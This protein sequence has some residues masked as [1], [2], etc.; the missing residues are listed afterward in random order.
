MIH[1]SALY[2]VENPP[3]NEE[4]KI[5]ANKD[6][7]NTLFGPYI[8]QN[9]TGKK[10]DT[11]LIP[12]ETALDDSQYDYVAIFFGADYCPHCKL[13]APKL[14]E[15]YDVLKAKKCKVV[16]ASNDRTAEA[17]DATC[18]KIAGIDVIPH[19]VTLTRKMRDLFDLKTIPAVVVLSNSEH[20]KD[21]PPIVTLD[22]RNKLVEDPKATK[23]PWPFAR[24]KSTENNTEAPVISGWDRF[25]ISGKYGKWYSLGHKANPLHPEKEYMDEHAVRIRAGILNVI[26]WVALMNVLFLK[27]QLFVRVV[28]PFVAWEFVS[29]SLFGLTPLA[30][31]GTVGVLG[32]M[33]L[34]P[35]PL[36][37]PAQPKRFAWAIGLTLATL[38]FTF[39]MIGK[40]QL[41]ATKYT[42]LVGSTVVTCNL[43]TW[44]ESSCGFCFG[45]FVWN[46]YLT[47][48][49]KLEECAECKI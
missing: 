19:D 39:V 47:K 13:F 32:S 4:S 48:W 36:W 31:F 5:A 25:I 12:T 34:H 30:P 46:N 8:L 23:F 16:A 38:C 17:F 6:W 37:K 14:L 28:W 21:T 7:R 10:D 33:L 43:F 2:D 3:V 15:S 44:L 22:G 40:D 27:N 45:C 1:D 26:T 42:W 29:S 35:Q 9:P 41:G 49:F 11:L 20:Q 18:S 24:D